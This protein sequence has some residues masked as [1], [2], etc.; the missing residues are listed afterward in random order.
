MKKYSLIAIIVLAALVVAAC[1]RNRN[2][3]SPE[4]DENAWMYD[5]TLPVP[6]L[7]GSGGISGVETKSPEITSLNGVKFRVLVMDT[8][9]EYVTPKVGSRQLLDSWATATGAEYDQLQFLSSFSGGSK[10]YYYP[11]TSDTVSRFNYSFYAAYYPNSSATGASLGINP[12]VSD[13]CSE[14][15][16]EFPMKTGSGDIYN[17]DVLHAKAEVDTPIEVGGV[18]YLG[19]NASYI[20]KKRDA[21]EPY[22]PNLAFNHVSSQIVLQV[23]AKDAAAA[24]TF[25]YVESAETVTALEVGNFTIA[26]RYEKAHLDLLTGVLSPAVDDEEEYIL[27]GASNTFYSGEWAVP[28]YPT[29]KIYP[30]SNP[31]KCGVFI[32]PG[33]RQNF[34][35]DADGNPIYAMDNQGNKILDET[36]YP[37]TTDLQ[38]NPV[39]VTSPSVTFQVR[40]PLE[41]SSTFPLTVELRAPKDDHDVT[42]FKPGYRYVY[43]LTI[44]SLESVVATLSIAAPWYDDTDLT[45]SESNIEIG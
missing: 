25:Q 22:I 32:I 29:A 12:V 28:T 31:T 3:L 44:N 10:K 11:M 30:F 45:T 18:K 27:S 9:D 1:N 42:R 38:G 2:K 40:K 34:R 33:E 8:H 16:V 26:G 23:V 7:L 43:T 39:V 37:Q 24:S 5:E 13:D 4:A 41:S 35:L 36:G 15:Y 14:A 17:V 19:Y 20:R 21:S 6:V